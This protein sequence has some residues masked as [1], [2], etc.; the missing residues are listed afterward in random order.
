MRKGTKLNEK[1]LVAFHFVDLR[2]SFS[3]KNSKID[4]FSKVSHGSF[5]SG[6]T[7]KG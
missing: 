1:I 4:L 7:R 6:V 2:S 3:S 5:V